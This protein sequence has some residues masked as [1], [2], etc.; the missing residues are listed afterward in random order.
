M[1][2]RLQSQLQV[3]CCIKRVMVVLFHPVIFAR[4]VLPA[5]YCFFI[6]LYC[7]SHAA[8]QLVSMKLNISSCCQC[9]LAT[10]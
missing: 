2:L 8:A 1:L 5:V 9:L 3:C 7:F 4:Q 10:F 6:A